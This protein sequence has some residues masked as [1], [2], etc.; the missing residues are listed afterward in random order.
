MCYAAETAGLQPRKRGWDGAVD[1]LVVRM[2]LPELERLPP[3]VVEFCILREWP[4]YYECKRRREDGS[5]SALFREVTDGRGPGTWPVGLLDESWNPGR[6]VVPVGVDHQD[7]SGW[8]K[9]GASGGRSWRR[10]RRRKRR[11]RNIDE[12]GPAH[13]ALFSTEVIS[14]S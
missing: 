8:C 6:Y 13:E 3:S 14:I 9:P 7:W 2:V 1:R 12:P 10:R 4:L 5:F 11:R